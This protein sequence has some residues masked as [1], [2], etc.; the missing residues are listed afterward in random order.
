MSR[1]ADPLYIYY[2]GQARN[3]E[4]WYNSIKENNQDPIYNNIEEKSTFT[5][6]VLKEA[7]YDKYSIWKY[8]EEIEAIEKEIQK[9]TNLKKD[10]IVYTEEL[11]KSLNDKKTSRISNL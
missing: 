1:D 8:D 7:N 3:F 6:R 9:V 4:K 5:K 11:L 2:I 10:L